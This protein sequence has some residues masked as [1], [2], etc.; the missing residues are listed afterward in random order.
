MDSLKEGW[1][2]LGLMEHKNSI[3]NH[4]SFHTPQTLIHIMVF[5]IF[6]EDGWPSGVWGCVI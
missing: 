5:L 2:W 1:G 3:S 6:Y 4:E